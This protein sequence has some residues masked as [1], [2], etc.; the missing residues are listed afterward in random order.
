M[1]PIES[2]AAII[3]ADLEAERT[4]TKLCCLPEVV[5]DNAE[6]GNV[7]DLP[8]SFGFGRATRFPLLDL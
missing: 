1:N 7:H 3:T 4:L 2:V 6:L 8:R 5:I